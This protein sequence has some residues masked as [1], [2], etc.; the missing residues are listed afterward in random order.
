M[1]RTQSAAG[2]GGAI[3]VGEELQVIARPADESQD[4]DRPQ[5]HCAEAAYR[6][7]VTDARQ[8]SAARLRPSSANARRPC[9]LMSYSSEGRALD[10][11]GGA[12]PF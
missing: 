6:V 5:H 8:N 3:I 7:V 10:A 12:Q 11:V 4:G 1:E 9:P 2:D